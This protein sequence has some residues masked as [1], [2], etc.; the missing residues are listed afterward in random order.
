MHLAELGSWKIYAMSRKDKLQYEELPD[1]L[2]Q[3]LVT[4]VKVDGAYII[5]TLFSVVCR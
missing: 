4:A 2:P 5:R 3:D 1:G